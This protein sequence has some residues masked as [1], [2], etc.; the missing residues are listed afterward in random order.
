VN[1]QGG[2]VGSNRGGG[3]GVEFLFVAV[4]PASEIF[5]LRRQSRMAH[6][7]VRLPRS[8]ARQQSAQA[9]HVQPAAV[10]K[11][12]KSRRPKTCLAGALQ[13]GCGREGPQDSGAQ[14]A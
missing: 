13:A 7:L 9:Q 6:Q 3:E 1:P 2:D 12:E 11:S 8:K 4:A 5:L 10:Q 14:Q